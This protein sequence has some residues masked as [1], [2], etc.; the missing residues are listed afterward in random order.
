[1]SPTTEVELYEHGDNLFLIR[2]G[3]TG[4]DVTSVVYDGSCKSTFANDAE[5][6]AEGDDT[7]W[8]CEPVSWDRINCDLTDRNHVH[9]CSADCPQLIATWDATQGV[10]IHKR[11]QYAQ[12]AAYLG[13]DVLAADESYEAYAD[14]LPLTARALSQMILEMRGNAENVLPTGLDRA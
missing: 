10:M 9:G 11:I 6:Y 4:H 8:S 13:V 1:M 7:D 5:G 14:I 12:V 2:E 3:Q